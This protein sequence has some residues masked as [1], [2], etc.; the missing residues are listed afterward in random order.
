MGNIAPLVVQWLMLVMPEAEKVR[1]FWPSEAI[2]LLV[3]GEVEDS[4]ST[5]I[6]VTSKRCSV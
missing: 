3:A 6:W 4:A 1:V 2:A 5:T